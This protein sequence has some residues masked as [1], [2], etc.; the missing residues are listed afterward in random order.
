MG[1]FATEG[2]INGRPTVFVVDTGATD[3]VLSSDRARKLGVKYKKSDR[4]K[5]T[6]ASRVETA[7]LTRLQSIRIGGIVRLNV[8]AIITKG[9]HPTIVLLG[10]S[11][12]SGLEI[13]QNGNE[14]ILNGP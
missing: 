1:R 6:T 10:M 9:K 4:I 14:M 13:T 3:I 12:L 7:Y 11:F 2:A 8:R 5:I